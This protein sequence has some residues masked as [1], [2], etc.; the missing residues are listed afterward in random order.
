MKEDSLFEMTQK[1]MVDFLIGLKPVCFEEWGTT[2]K[3]YLP[4]P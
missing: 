3:W 4:K 2:Q 1:A